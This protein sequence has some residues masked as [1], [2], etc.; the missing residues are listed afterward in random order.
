MSKVVEK[1][2]F[3][4]FPLNKSN[5]NTY[6]YYASNPLLNFEFQMN[7]TRQIKPDSLRLV[8]NFRIFQRSAND[9]LPANRFDLD[10]KA[11]ISADQKVCYPDDR[12]SVSSCIQTLTIAN[13]VGWCY[14]FIQRLV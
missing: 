9:K 8:G 12:V 6:S 3:K 11:A 13:L 14:F 10:C 2:E 7:G 5:T 4:L 1:Q